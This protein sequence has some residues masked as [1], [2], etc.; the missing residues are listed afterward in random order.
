MSL[1]FTTQVP[2]NLMTTSLGNET[3]SFGSSSSS[4]SNIEGTYEVIGTS[5]KAN[6]GGIPGTAPVVYNP[7][8]TSKNKSSKS[9]F[10]YTLDAS[11]AGILSQRQREFY[12]ENGFLVIPNLVSEEQIDECRQR[13][14]D[15]I[16]GKVD[17]GSILKMKDLSLKVNNKKK[18][19][20]RIKG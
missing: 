7:V 13:F 14:L 6:F 18:I 3:F 11:S 8:R 4:S 19:K 20:N 1:G 16:D 2:V 5:E 12:E 9:S 17:S 15:I 10:K